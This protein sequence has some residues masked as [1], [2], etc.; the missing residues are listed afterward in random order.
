MWMKR[1]TTKPGPASSMKKL[2]KYWVD[3][4]DNMD[5][6]RIKAWIERLPIHIQEVLRLEGGN[7][8]KESKSGKRRNP[9]RVH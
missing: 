1:E 8:Y 9:D 5:Q 4:W 2:T 7:E 6:A 3:C